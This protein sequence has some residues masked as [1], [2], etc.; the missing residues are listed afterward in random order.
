MVIQTYPLLDYARN[1]L[2]PLTRPF[3]YSAK[4]L[5]N[6]GAWN[7]ILLTMV[8]VIATM[9]HTPQHNAKARPK[10]IPKW[11]RAQPTFANIGRAYLSTMYQATTTYVESTINGWTVQRRQQLTMDEHKTYSILRTAALTRRRRSQARRGALLAFTALAMSTE[12]ASRAPRVRFDTDSKWVGIDNRCSACISCDEKDFISELRPSG[13]KIKGFGGVNHTGNIMTGTLRWTWCD[14][15]GRAHTFTIP[16]SYYVPDGKTRLLS[17]QHW[18]KSQKDKISWGTHEST[19]GTECVLYWQQ[20]QHQLTIPL[21]DRS[22]VATLA[23]APGYNDYDIYCQEVGITTRYDDS[24]L[25]RDPDA[26]I[27]SDDEDEDTPPSPSPTPT[28]SPSIQ[29]AKEVWRP[30]EPHP[31]NLDLDGPAP[32]PRTPT[33]TPTDTPSQ[34][35]A[36]MDKTMQ[37]MMKLHQRLN[38]ISFEKIRELARQGALPKAYA[39]CDIPVCTSCMYSKMTRRPWRNKRRHDRAPATTPAVGEVVSVD[40]MVSSTQGFIAQM[41]GILTTSRYKYATVYVDQGSRLGYVYLQK[42]ASAEETIRGKI[43]FELYARSHGI[44]IKG[45][46]ADNGIFRANKWVEHCLSQHQRLSFAGVNAHHQNG[47]AERRIR[48]LQELARTMMIH[49]ARRWPKCITANLWPYAI[50]MANDAFNHCPNMKDTTRRSPLQIFGNTKVAMNPKHFQPFG[51]PVYVLDNALQHGAPFQKWKIRSRVGIYLGKSPTHSNNVALVLDR[52]TGLVSPQFHVK[53]DPSFHSVMQDELD[54]QWQNRAGFIK[55]EPATKPAKQSKAKTTSKTKRGRGRPREAPTPTPAPPAAPHIPHSEWQHTDSNM[56]TTGTS[57]QEGAMPQQE[58]AVPQQEGAQLHPETVL[59]APEGAGP[60]VGTTI[61]GKRPGDPLQHQ[62]GPRAPSAIITRS[63]RLK[64][65]QLPRRVNFVTDDGSKSSSL[66]SDGMAT[67]DVGTDTSQHAYN[68]PHLIAMATEISACTRDDIEG[69]L[70]CLEAMFPDH[71]DDY[72]KLRMEQDP[73]YAYKATSD[74]DT[75]YMHEAM[76]EPDADQFKA[77]MVKEVHDQMSGKIWTLVPR[78]QVPEGQIILPAV[79]QMK[80]KRDIKTNTIKKYKAR[81]NIDGSRMIKGKH[82][83]QTYAP[84]ASWKC[85]RLL[86]IL[87]AKY[88][89]HSRQLDYVLAF[90]QAPVE[91]E[92]YMQIPK[93]F[94]QDLPN[95]SEKHVLKIHRNIYGQKQAGRVWFQYLRDKLINELNFKQSK[96]DECV[97]YRGRTMYVLYTDDSLL[98]GPD[99]DEIEQII[100][101][102][103]RAHLNITDEGDIQDFLGVNIEMKTNGEIHLTQPHLIE[104]ILKELKF[105]ENGNI[106]AKEIPAKSSEI[107]KRDLEGKD[108][109]GSFHYRSIIGKL[110]YLEKATRGDIAYITHQCARFTQNPKKE[111]GEALR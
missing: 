102:L 2:D 54:S 43:A 33:G 76:R 11:K 45:Y 110:N 24:A 62:S 82:Y 72:H 68:Q 74:P 26:A 105:P 17:P 37:D 22:N 109:D 1:G 34:P 85:I 73:L 12:A 98:A 71:V 16:N 111:H 13:R 91:R 44:T 49:A 55:Q 75:M 46:H 5:A 7:C 79:W 27:V 65:S 51:C 67:P 4:I 40:Q 36:T 100:R 18:A 53:F 83:E 89:W 31:F 93:G 35:R 28:P 108:F 81:L 64:T 42:T 69:E 25:I 39:K 78:S 38:H 15:L 20:R 56:S 32:A 66:G 107:L 14:D 90:P 86:L 50:R 19:N 103:K 80:R 21:D 70:L 87:V 88:G 9:L 29:E 63:K 23:L 84:V 6:I 48:E 96:I 104:Q 58:G 101:D 41:T 99:N 92:I 77:A 30:H 95:G 10:Y 47:I 61:P 59:P 94:E 60:A 8:Y 57:Q 52:T 97:F 3:I 106:T